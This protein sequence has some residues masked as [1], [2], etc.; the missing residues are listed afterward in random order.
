[1]NCGILEPSTP[2]LSLPRLLNVTASFPR[3][4]LLRVEVSRHCRSCCSNEQRAT[5]NEQRATSNE[6]RATS[7]EQR[8]T[9]N[10]QRARGFLAKETRQSTDALRG[11]SPLK[12]EHTHTHTHTHILLVCLGGV[13]VCLIVW[14]RERVC[15]CAQRARG[16]ATRHAGRAY[17]Y[18]SCCTYSLNIKAQVPK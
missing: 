9:S 7:N 11:C 15:T 13:R 16:S 10:E 3:V 8:A 12:Q 4:Q 5:S 18:R 1:M 2:A 14:E 6:Q 17:S